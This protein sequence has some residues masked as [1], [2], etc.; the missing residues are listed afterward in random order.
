[1]TT[2]NGTVLLTF[3]D[4]SVAHWYSQ[5]DLLSSTGTRA[6]FFISHPD[7]L[8]DSDTE[9]LQSLAADGHTIAVHGLRHVDAP[10]HLAEHG[11]ETYLHDEIVP[12]IDELERRGLARRD[13]AYP[14]GR[15]DAA[16]DALLTQHFSWLRATSPR[17]TD[18]E[19]ATAVLFDPADPTS[20]RVVPA[21]GI[22]VG[23]RGEP[24]HDDSDVLLALL[25]RAADRG[26]TL[27]LYAHDVDSL[28]GGFAGQ[29]N[30]VTPERLHEVI[31]AASVR[32]LA[33]RPFAD[34]PD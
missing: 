16:T 15:R 24:N 17:T 20:G 30:F 32:G 2:G 1:M 31:E 25:D 13:F 28:E 7:G 3:D 14:Y 29:R 8:S 21:R 22:D 26:L 9:Q 19:E 5:R 11:P 18:V 34:L 33:L 12:A 4:R 10:R 27:C 23:R 6:T